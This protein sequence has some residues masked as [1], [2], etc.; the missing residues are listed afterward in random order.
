MSNF[1]QVIDH[2]L[3][4]IPIDTNRR[5]IIIIIIIIILLLL[6]LLLLL[7]FLLLSLTAKRSKPYFIPLERGKRIGRT[8][9]E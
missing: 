1:Y 3:R 4:S 7:F 6:L 2:L 9:T 5:A 8:T